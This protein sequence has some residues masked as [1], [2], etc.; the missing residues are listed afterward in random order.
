MHWCN[1]ACV[2]LH[3]MALVVLP[4]EMNDRVLVMEAALDMDGQGRSRCKIG[5]TCDDC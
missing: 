1:P 3:N 2:R 4:G 5:W